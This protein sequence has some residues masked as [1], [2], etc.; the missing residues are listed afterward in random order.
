MSFVKPS[1]K[2]SAP[3]QS[4]FDDVC[5]P[6]SA[7]RPGQGTYHGDLCPIGHEL[8]PGSPWREDGPEPTLK[9][10]RKTRGPDRAPR[11]HQ[12]VCRRGHALLTDADF[13]VRPVGPDGREG[14]RECRACIVVRAVASALRR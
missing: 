2:R 12:T 1:Y 7:S 13:Y 14:R 5:I 6:A 10:K 4:D 9:R 3:I 8:L 11:R